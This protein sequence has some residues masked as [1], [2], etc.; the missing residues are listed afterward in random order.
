VPYLKK[1]KA[2]IQRFISWFLIA[3]R[4]RMEFDEPR[5]LEEAIRKLKY[6]YEQSKCRSKTRPDWRGNYNNKG[7][8]DKESVARPNKFNRSGKG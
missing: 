6:F 1:E 3:F 2:K 7:N 4:Y 8:W 5:S